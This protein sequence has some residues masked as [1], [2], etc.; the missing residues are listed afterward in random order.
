MDEQELKQYEDQ[1]V[2]TLLYLPGC[3]SGLKS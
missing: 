3:K 1:Y 2:P